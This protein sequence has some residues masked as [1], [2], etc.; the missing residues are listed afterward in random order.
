MHF[1]TEAGM[2]AISVVLGAALGLLAIASF[3]TYIKSFFLIF[4]KALGG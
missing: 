2:R 3:L 1:T 4:I